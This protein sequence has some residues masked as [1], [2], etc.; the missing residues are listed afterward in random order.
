MR[1]LLINPWEGEVFPPPSI[2]YLQGIIRN[3][4]VDVKAID[5]G[6]VVT[7][8]DDYDIIAVSYHSFSVKQARMIRNRFKNRLIC[9]GHH[10]TALPEQMLSIGYDQVVI[11][12]GENAIIDIINGNTSKIVK[13]EFID[14]NSTPYPDYSGLSGRWDMGLPIISSRGCPFS[15]SF[16][17]SSLFWHR[18]YRM[19]SVD[20]VL[21]ELEFRIKQGYKQWMFEDDNFT[22]SKKRAIEICEGIIRM[23]KFSWQCASRAESLDNELCKSLVKAGCH[24][25]WLGVESLSQDSLNRVNKHTTVDKI[26]NGIQTAHNNGLGTMSQFIVGI[27]G[28]NVNNILETVTNIRKGKVGRRGCNIIWILPNTDIHAKA[29]NKGFNDDIYLKYGAPFYTYEQDI[30]TLNSWVNIINNG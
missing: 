12:E 11:G 7:E 20:N 19:R 6:G 3:E 4:G 23:G 2:G 1:V 27:P 10:P 9:G 13:G 5:I 16:C 24:T 30:N 14:I 17:A 21:G 25:V 26:L 15:C 18:G 29:K 8:K 22:V 28:D